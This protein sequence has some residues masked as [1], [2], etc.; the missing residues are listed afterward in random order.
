[1]NEKYIPLKPHMETIA[2]TAE[3]FGVSQYFVRK[4]A[5]SGK[6]VA[7][8]ISG[9]IL[10]NCDKFAEYLNTATLTPPEQSEKNVDNMRR[11]CG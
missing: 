2:R 9:R 4:L 11:I 10:I 8:R 1:M 3:L 7:V 6:I 5:L